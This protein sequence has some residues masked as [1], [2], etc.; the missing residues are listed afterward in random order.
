[1]WL[2][3]QGGAVV[4]EE[5]VDE[6]V[7]IADALEEGEFGAVVEEVGVVPKTHSKVPGFK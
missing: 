7:A 1:M 6:A 3:G 5:F 4:L 2:G